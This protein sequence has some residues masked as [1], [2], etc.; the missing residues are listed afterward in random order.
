MKPKRAP[1][2]HRE[3]ESSTPASQPD[4][5][6]HS[7]EWLHM[8]SQPSEQQTHPHEFHQ[9]DHEPDHEEDMD[10]SDTEDAELPSSNNIVRTNQLSNR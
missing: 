6:P 7:E 5:L 1:E 4:V 3:M 8:E 2:Q 9:I 10:H